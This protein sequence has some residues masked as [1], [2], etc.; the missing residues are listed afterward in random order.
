MKVLFIRRAAITRE[1]KEWLEPIQMCCAFEC[2]TTLLLLPPAAAQA[3]QCDEAFAE[4]FGLGIVAIHVLADSSGL[5]STI[6]TKADA[7]ALVHAHHIVLN[8]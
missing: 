6:S 7:S 4:L 2:Q 3:Q 1:D 5:H 8:A